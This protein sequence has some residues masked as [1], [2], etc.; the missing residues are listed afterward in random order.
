MECTSKHNQQ[1]ARQVNENYSQGAGL[2]QTAK[3][4]K[5]LNTGHLKLPHCYNFYSYMLQPC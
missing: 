1:N 5:I 2:D 4:K 3:A